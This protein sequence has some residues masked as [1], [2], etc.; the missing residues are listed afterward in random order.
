MEDAPTTYMLRLADGTEFGP[1]DMDLL[2]DWARQGRVPR[3]GLLVAT[4]DPSSVRSV[5]AEQRIARILSAP[6]TTRVPVAPAP[7]R[8]T[9]LVPYR[10]PYALV[11]YYMGI[12]SLMPLIGLLLAIPAFILGIMGW[13]NYRK[14]PEIRGGVHAWV[15][16]IMGG[17][18]TAVW[19]FALVAM[20]VSAG[21]S[22]Y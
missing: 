4:A 2:E 21:R 16:I 18:L 15:G 3:D 6:P 12:F 20:V 5:F 10:N 22:G 11:A 17:L 7:Q 1:A 19:A 8:A 9:G 14:T 13:R